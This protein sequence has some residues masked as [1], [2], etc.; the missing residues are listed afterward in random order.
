MSYLKFL[1]TT[2]CAVALG[3][4][5]APKRADISTTA[6]PAEEMPKL[7][8]AVNEGLANQYDVLAPE[9]FRKSQEW[10]KEAKSDLS[11]NEP[12]KEIL[13]DIRKS[14]GYLDRATSK[15]GTR[16]QNAD[17]VL[18]A[19]KAALDA[20]A[21]NFSKTRE[22]LKNIDDKFRSYSDDLR[23]TSP[24]K[25]SKLQN[26]YLQLQTNTVQTT[27]LG[28]AEAGLHAAKKKNAEKYAP[29]SYRTAEMDYRTALNQIAANR[30]NP[31]NYKD[32]VAKSLK[33]AEYLGW[34]M[35]EARKNGRTINENAA[36]TIVNQNLQIGSLKSELAGANQEARQMQSSLADKEQRLKGLSLQES[37][38]KARKEFSPDEA[39]VYQQGDK[40][41]LR[42]KAMHFPSGKAELPTASLSLLAKV[43]EVAEDLGPQSVV[44][45]GHT[46]S[47]GKASTNQLLSQERAESV[48]TYLG[49]NGID[50]DKLQA[51]GYGYKKPIA[52]NKSKMG[53]AQNRRV[54]IL[55]TPAQSS[56]EEPPENSRTPATPQPSTGE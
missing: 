12:S 1:A 10:L 2:F 28:R 36:I 7:E 27:E 5:S 55:I 18:Q 41:L 21:R 9:D 35:A 47:T 19:R 38:A 43:K 3:C 45:E 34:V 56:S 33:S 53:R 37:L 4:S 23:D 26:Q 32:A 50:Q 16:T 48:A 40:L 44:V 31:E 13:D 11:K 54:D 46:D 14:Y 39:E 30:D 6:A 20:G 15:A 49:E 42:L 8:T 51:V 24:A 22:Q 17:G 52:S 29:R 25:L